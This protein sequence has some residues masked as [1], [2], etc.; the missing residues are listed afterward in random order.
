MVVIWLSW[1]W[2]AVHQALAHSLFFCFGISNNVSI[3]VTLT[4]FSKFLPTH[5]I[6]P[7]RILNWEVLKSSFLRG[8][9]QILP[10]ANGEQRSMKRFINEEILKYMRTLR[11]TYRNRGFLDRW[12][13]MFRQIFHLA[14]IWLSKQ[15][16]YL[17]NERRWFAWTNQ[18]K[19]K[20]HHWKLCVK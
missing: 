11:T 8:V 4:G 1:P 5:S 19:Y 3:Q 7:R 20:T 15:E 17:L 13:P 2:A 16:V 9:E 14:P 6:V 10:L 12:L 18:T